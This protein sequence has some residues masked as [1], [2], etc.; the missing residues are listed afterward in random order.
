MC[1]ITRHYF[2][3]SVIVPPSSNPKPF[4]VIRD[5]TSVTRMVKE[6]D[7]RTEHHRLIAI[8][9]RHYTRGNVVETSC[10][11]NAPRPCKAI[12]DVFLGEIEIRTQVLGCCEVE[13]ELGS[14]RW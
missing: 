8:L 11:D 5:I 1:A 2:L 4:I 9:W 14:L 12:Q 13:V 3:T 6:V 7:P 10:I